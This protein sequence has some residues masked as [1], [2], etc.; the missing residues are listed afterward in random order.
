M[1]DITTY[2]KDWYRR[3]SGGGRHI[4]GIQFHSYSTG[5]LRYARISED[6]QI[7]TSAIGGDASTYEAAVIGHGHLLGK[8]GKVKRFR[9]QDAAA[10][11]AIKV[12]RALK[13]SKQSS[14]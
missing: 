14:P 12:F 10:R 11:A 7:M 13:P 1:S 2:V 5:I 6:G 8:S 3:T 9:T 4:D